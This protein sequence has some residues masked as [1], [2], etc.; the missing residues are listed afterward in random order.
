MNLLCLML[1]IMLHQIING[2]RRC[3]VVWI[4]LYLGDQKTGQATKI[5][6]KFDL[7]I[8][9]F[10][11]LVK[12]EVPNYLNTVDPIHLVVYPPG[13]PLDA[14]HD[15]DRLRCGGP[16]PGGRTDEQPLVM[17]IAPTLPLQRNSALGTMTSR[18]TFVN[19]S[20]ERSATFYYET[21]KNIM[22]IAKK[23][24]DK[25]IDLWKDHEECE[26]ETR[27]D[28]QEDDEAQS[29]EINK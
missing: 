1:Q 2:Q 3:W 5:R 6:C 13:T 9:D 14:L 10:T 8:D 7:D 22:E 26:Q 17:V 29:V 12:A 18:Q 16:V 28:I 25:M 20:A 11:K 24:M 23:T 4:Q 15:N 21:S 27:Q 19:A